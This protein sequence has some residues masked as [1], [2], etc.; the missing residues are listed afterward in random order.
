MNSPTITVSNFAVF[1]AGDIDQPYAI[2]RTVDKEEQIVAKVRSSLQP[3]NAVYS[4]IG[5][6]PLSG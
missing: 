1:S 4:S 2:S 3:F 5:H 6:S